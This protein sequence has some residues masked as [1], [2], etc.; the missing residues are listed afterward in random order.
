MVTKFNKLILKN[1]CFL[2]L[3]DFKICEGS[4]QSQ[5]GQIVLKNI[6]GVMTSPTQAYN[7]IHHPLIALSVCLMYV[8]AYQ[9]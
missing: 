5:M 3:T 2:L 9:Y 8:W 4:I 6:L 7:S 1:I